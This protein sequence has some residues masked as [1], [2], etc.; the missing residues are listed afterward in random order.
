M[1]KKHKIL[2]AV[3][4]VAIIALILVFVF[5]PRVGANWPTFRTGQKTV[6]AKGTPEQMS[7]LVIAENVHLVIK[8]M[9]AN[10]GAVYVGY[11]SATALNTNSD[12]FSLQPGESIELKV[13]N[14]NDIWL[15]A[16]SGE[17]VEYVTEYDY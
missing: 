16:E 11:S 5:T 12:Y 9:N 3:L 1:Q 13:D 17:G 14:A 2:S 8:A 6:T 7:S 15:D 10:T 4:G